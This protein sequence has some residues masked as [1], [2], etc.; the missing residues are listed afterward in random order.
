MGVALHGRHQIGNEIGPALILV[1]HLAPFGLDVLILPRGVVDT[2]TGQP[3]KHNHERTGAGK[4]GEY[5]LRHGE[6]ISFGPM[7][8]K[9][10]SSRALSYT[11]E[12]TDDHNKNAGFS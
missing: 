4:R 11:S 8:R 6:M 2:A 10:V 3:H 9:I 7:T 12:G 5:R 1:Q